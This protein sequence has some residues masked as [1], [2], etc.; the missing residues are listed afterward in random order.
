MPY[1]I[2]FMETKTKYT[3]R[4][5]PRKQHVHGLWNYFVRSHL[6]SILH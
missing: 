5:E 1:Q 2:N 4:T 6:N 3:N